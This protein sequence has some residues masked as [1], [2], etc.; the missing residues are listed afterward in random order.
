MEKITLN[1]PLK[2]RVHSALWKNN[3]NTSTVLSLCNLGVDK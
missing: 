1:E 3:D 2:D